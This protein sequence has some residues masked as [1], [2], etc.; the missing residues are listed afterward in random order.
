MKIFLDDFIVYGDM[1]SHM[2]LKLCNK[3]CE[4]YII[5]F[6]PKKCAFMVFSKLILGF[7]VSEEGKIL[8]LKK[9]QTIMNMQ[10]LTNP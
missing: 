10:I 1:H 7:I 3:K 9:V 8:D 5:S 2:K 4:I 6:N